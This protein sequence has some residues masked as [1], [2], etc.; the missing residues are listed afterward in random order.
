MSIS[1]ETLAAYV[2]GT[3]SPRARARVDAALAN[4]PALAERLRRHVTVKGIVQ[5]AYGA[6]SDESRRTGSDGERRRPAQVVQLAAV[7]EARRPPKR[8]PTWRPVH[9]AI[10]AGTLL[11]GGLLGR[12]LPSGNSQPPMIGLGQDGMVAQGSLAQSLSRQ[13]SQAPRL[14]HGAVLIYSTFL[15]NEGRWC[16]VFRTFSSQSS[17]DGIACHDSGRWLIRMVQALPRNAPGTP[18]DAEQMPREGALV[19]QAVAQMMHGAPA[20]RAQEDRLLQSNWRG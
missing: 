9:L 4:D 3:L 17:K 10:L 2:A 20:T 6:V 18:Q 7:R 12:L 1:D 5:N 15:D 8:P 19:Q 16:R 11:L 13:R 14:G